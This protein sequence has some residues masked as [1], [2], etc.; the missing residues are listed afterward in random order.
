MKATLERCDVEIGC[1]QHG[2]PS[3]RWVTRW[4][5]VWPDGKTRTYP[6]MTIPQARAYCK[7]KGWD[8]DRS[9]AA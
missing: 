7:A 4:L 2:K 1:A 6:A 8:L 3:Y 9:T 5:V